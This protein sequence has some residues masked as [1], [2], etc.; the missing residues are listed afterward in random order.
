MAFE[1]IPSQLGIDTSNPDLAVADQPAEDIAALQDFGASSDAPYLEEAKNSLLSFINPTQNLSVA[2]AKRALLG[3]TNNPKKAHLIAAQINKEAMLGKEG[4]SLNGVPFAYL[5]P[6]QQKV[7]LQK[8]EEEK[9]AQERNQRSWVKDSQLDTTGGRIKN[10][11]ANVVAGTTEF[12]GEASVMGA[13]TLNFL[14]N[15]GL[16]ESDYKMYESIQNKMS[17]GQDL[18]KEELS[19]YSKTIGGEGSDKTKFDVIG[20]IKQRENY[21]QSIEAGI[22][23]VGKIVNDKKTQIALNKV[24][25]KAENALNKFSEGEYLDAVGTF[26]KSLYDLATEDTQAAAELTAR[27]LPQMY[28]MARSAL[29][30]VSQMTA[31]GYDQAIADFKAE[32]GRM[33]NNEEKAVAGIASLVSAGLDAMG[34]K[35]TFGGQK[36]LTNIK[37]VAEK[38][39]LKT[40]SKTFAKA[41]NAVIEAGKSLTK[42]ALGLG[43]KTVKEV[44]TSHPVKSLFVEGGTEG[45]Q[46]AVSQFAAKQD[47]SKIDVK[48]VLTETAVGSVVGFAISSPGSAAHGA[49]RTLS[50]LEKRKTKAAKK[51]ADYLDRI[52]TE[53]K[54]SDMEKVIQEAKDTDN[55]ELGIE[56]I[57]RTGIDKLDYKQRRNVIKD[58]TKFIN[59]HEKAAEG[60]KNPEERAAALKQNDDYRTM[61]NNVIEVHNQLSTG[62]TV[63]DA[64]NVLTGKEAKPEEAKAAADT[65]VNNVVGTSTV[66]LKVVNDVLGSED[67]KKNASPEDVKVLETNR[68]LLESSTLV[69]EAVNQRVDEGKTAARVNKDIING[70]KGF[71]GIK[72]YMSDLRKAVAEGNHGA[73]AAIVTKLNQFK[74]EHTDK[75]NKGYYDKKNKVWKSHK[76]DIAAFIQKEIDALDA[77]EKYAASVVEKTF[78][79]KVQPEPTP[80]RSQGA[81]PGGAEA[82]VSPSVKVTQKKVLTHDNAAQ[83]YDRLTKIP[84]YIQ[85]ALGKNYKDAL[86]AL[87]A[88]QDSPNV[89]ETFFT[90]T[91]ND[92]QKLSAK[93]VALKKKGPPQ[94]KAETA[95]AA[96]AQ[97]PATEKP[98]KVEPSIPVEE[99][100]AEK[101]S[102]AAP[103]AKRGLKIPV[104]TMSSIGALYYR[105]KD[106]SPSAFK[107]KK[108]QAYRDRLIKQ[109]ETARA[110]GRLQDALPAIQKSVDKLYSGLKSTDELVGQHSR[111]ETTGDLNTDLLRNTMTYNTPVKGDTTSVSDRKTLSTYFRAAT[112]SFKTN[113][114][115]TT[116]NMFS[117][118]AGETKQEIIDSLPELTDEQVAILDKL[119]AFNE[120]FSSVLIGTPEKPGILKLL[121]Q[122]FIF[123]NNLE[124]YF[125]TDPKRKRFNSKGD[126]SGYLIQIDENGDRYLNENLVSALAMTAYNW[127]ATQ[128]RSTLS[129][130]EE[131]I[132]RILGWND[133]DPISNA[134]FQKFRDVGTLRNSLA[135]T[136]GAQA[137]NLLGLQT[138]PDSQIDGD[139]QAKME[140]AL[141]EMIISTLN[142]AGLTEQV[143]IP[144]AEMRQHVNL[145]EEFVDVDTEGESKTNFIRIANE[146]HSELEN[147]RQPNPENQDIIDTLQ[148][149]KGIMTIL[150]DINSYKKGP[151]TTPIKTVSQTL[152][153]LPFVKTSKKLRAVVKALQDVEWGVKQNMLDVYQFLGAESLKDILGYERNTD[154]MHYNLRQGAITANERILRSLAHVD[155]W[156]E[157]NKDNPAAT[158]YFEHEV[159]KNNR[160]GMSSNTINPQNDKAHRHLFGTRMSDIKV[161]TD[162][163]KQ[164]F[165]AAVVQALGK[166]VDGYGGIDKDTFTGINQAFETIINDPEIQAA[167]EAIKNPSTEEHRQAIIAAVAKGEENMHSLD[168]LVALAEALDDNFKLKDKFQTNISVETDGITNGVIIGLMQTMLEDNMPARLAAGGVFTDGIHTDYG[169]WKKESPLHNDSYETLADSWDAYLNEMRQSG[170]ISNGDLIF[171]TNLLGSLKEDKSV[172]DKTTTVVS[173][174]GRKLSKSP[175]MTTNYGSS[176]TRIIEMLGDKAEESL[177]KAL[178]KA[179]EEQDAVAAMG[180]IVAAFNKFTGLNIA[181]PKPG[182]EIDWVLSDKHSKQ[183]RDKI[184]QSSG[185]ALRAAL[186]DQFQ[187]FTKVRTKINESMKVMFTAFQIQ[188]DKRVKAAIAAKNE[189]NAPGEPEKALT[190]KEKEVILEDLLTLMPGVR[191]AFGTG[192]GDGVVVLKTKF[193]RDYTNYNKGIQQNY[194]VP[195][196]NSGSTLSES[197]SGTISEI[198]F[199][200]PGVAGS[201]MIIQALDSAVIGEVALNYDILNV[202]DAAMFPINQVSTGTI[203]FN[204]SFMKIMENYNIIDEIVNS[205][206]ETI[207]EA[208]IQEI[209]TELNT[210]IR[211][212]E[213]IE[214]SN[215]DEFMD[216]VRELQ[217]EVRK[218]REQIEVTAMS[219]FSYPNSAHIP[220]E[221]EQII[222]TLEELLGEEVN[223]TGDEFFSNDAIEIDF[224]TFASTYNATLTGQNSAEI[225]EHLENM[226]NV[227]KD[228]EHQAQLRDLLHN[229]INKVISPLDAG[230]IEFDLKI[231][232]T[233]NITY[234]AVKGKKIRIVTGKG[235]VGHN[236][237]ISTQEALVHELIHAI[238][239]HGLNNN[240][241][242]RRQLRTI[243]DQAK[244]VITV[245]AFMPKD[246]NGNTIPNPT[247]EQTKAAQDRWDYIFNSENQLHEFLAFGLTNKIFRDQLA[248]ITVKGK[249]E[250]TGNSLKDALA[251]IYYAILDFFSGKIKGLEGKP[252]DAAILSLAEAMSSVNYRYHKSLLAKLDRINDFNSLVVDGLNKIVFQPWMDFYKERGYPNKQELHKKI[253]EVARAINLTEKSF[254]VKL[255]REI[256]GQTPSNYKWH[257]LLRYSKKYIDQMRKYQSDRIA[258]YLVDAFHTDLTADD[259]TALTKVILKTDMSSLLDN[260]SIDQIKT[261]LLQPGTLQTE[262]DA[263]EAQLA[264][265]GNN[266]NFY[267]QQ[268][269]SLGHL[270]ATGDALIRGQ[271]VN[272]HNIA[273]IFGIPVEATGDLAVA[274]QLI[275]HLA[276]LNAMKHT[277]QY[278]KNQVA[279]LIGK[280]YKA[281]KTENGIDTLLYSHKDFKERSLQSLFEGNKTQMKKGYIHEIYDPDVSIQIA[282]IDEETR[283]V[284]EDAGYELLADRIKTDKNIPKEFRGKTLGLY[285]NKVGLNTQVKTIASLTSRIHS[286]TDLFHAALSRG[287][288]TPSVE[289][290]LAIDKV[291]DKVSSEVLSQFTSPNIQPL[292]P[293][294]K[295]LIPVV[296]EQGEIVNFRYWMN[297]HTR[298]TVLDRDNSF[299]K[300]L[301][302]MH[303]SITDKVNSKVINRDVIK[304]AL[305]DYNKFYKEDPSAFVEIS[306]QS[307]DKHYKEIYTMMPEEMKQDI[308]DIW[309]DTPLLVREELIDLIFGYRKLS[310]ADSPWFKGQPDK[311]DGF[312]GFSNT[313]VGK[314]LKLDKNIRQA[315]K[316]WYELVG[317][318]KDNIVIRSI[319]V[320]QQNII[321]NNFLLW[322]KGV[323]IGNIIRDQSAALKEVA[324]YHAKVIERDNLEHTLRTNPNLSVQRK[325]KL[326]KQIASLTSEINQNTVKELVDEGIFQAIVEDINLTDPRYGYQ[327]KINKKFAPIKEQI[328]EPLTNVVKQAFFTKDT[329]IYQKL[330]QATLYSDF[331]AR[332]ALFKH[333]TQNKK[334]SKEAAILEIVE[335]F[336]NYDVPTSPEMQYMNDIGFIMFTKF[337]FRIQKVIY[338]LLKE[339]PVNAL[340]LAAMEGVVGDVSDIS[341]SNLITTSL[342]HRMHNFV[343]DIPDDVTYVAGV[344]AV[345]RLF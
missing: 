199:L 58:L 248:Q 196:K 25:A 97:A 331:V 74:T 279:V 213:S 190:K 168:G 142:H 1:D 289:A 99:K 252:A 194:T 145:Q 203:D 226:D 95:P 256:A 265:Y 94:K 167:V 143:D 71:V 264:A 150:F 207:G 229:L 125:S 182:E 66:S 69:E 275:D 271:R 149:S 183:F 340:S 251:R 287:S 148:N 193:T 232:E 175:L 77:A 304:L 81:S 20:D 237:Q 5:T 332:Y 247:A 187:G 233:G 49:A 309:G 82:S 158:L 282:P 179:S 240:P 253:R 79:E 239:A 65:F 171:I 258:S 67:F 261:F 204:A 31:T 295:V 325:N 155:E 38:L 284:Y 338:K 219:Q 343:T 270:M 170:E 169:A 300:V 345:G 11:A 36:F 212:D 263:I 296:N 21:I 2:D 243:F 189:N 104:V 341:D 53:N 159:W 112:K 294:S 10:F 291:K 90:K 299:E 102:Q 319:V 322:A 124:G 277:N 257:R 78:G 286:G 290:M 164:M 85:E 12:V 311:K 18:N 45:A 320:L 113:V 116:H 186:T 123:K 9:Q 61:L 119:G 293:K 129:N 131:D 19:F 16:N 181:A 47:I 108:V 118:L 17:S 4:P 88:L 227:P 184:A 27:T 306:R 30:G 255:V 137:F 135:E 221:A 76:S 91:Q 334:M 267:I 140:M 209:T 146:P 130:T 246:Q 330:T 93:I 210:A 153:G 50:S 136:L 217:Q 245:D 195:I 238:T 48:Q 268:A 106:L 201:A 144:A 200:D 224:E 173:E 324:D 15:L 59:K 230:E 122:D 262:I 98:A 37:K 228:P 141:G 314:L 56:A 96:K 272:A 7:A 8:R 127:I 313:E 134:T 297:E 249:K 52:I 54:I 308:K 57:S 166:V 83:V 151:V 323:P 336:V 132:K 23:D 269:T 44:V 315:E 154:A 312:I 191:N 103:A 208:T 198:T 318:A 178:M 285:V 33:P 41:D 89:P 215:V 105:I 111:D 337:L 121:T 39:G 70:G 6:E 157:L 192:R 218:A 177:Y 283:K 73:A 274:E 222:N 223:K 326:K 64:Y 55:P 260:Y 120:K 160:I 250:V 302:G 87:Q 51:A 138:N 29:L 327:A 202:F 133:E 236:N 235:T 281:S 288:M 317:I 278:W 34:A 126:P 109:I 40:A 110:E 339:H 231:D 115:R 32:H 333:L 176:I 24:G 62:G 63:E 266:G 147:Y 197:A 86:V 292:D 72:Q 35:F 242:L 225:F 156:I 214:A 101:P 117:R 307:A 276:T 165:R 298:D 310:L 329:Y 185:A 162:H 75:L 273:N 80:A 259:K 43:A 172:D 254:I 161:S 46:S 14:N 107:D 84:A 92:I 100:A 342:V 188:Y 244:K 28:I 316:I 335:T 301:G 303:G 205:L 139:I 216:T 321:S 163:Q 234:G 22:A 305:E 344:E 152:K 26:A 211:K 68:D 220:A 60:I 206:E 280:E 328:P 128:G 3:F 13:R 241:A 42:T 180:N 114:L 174:V